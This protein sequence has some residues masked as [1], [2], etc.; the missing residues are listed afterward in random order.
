M[1]CTFWIHIKPIIIAV[2]EVE[3]DGSRDGTY[4]PKVTFCYEHNKRLTQLCAMDS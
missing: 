3:E 2:Y 4:G 1:L